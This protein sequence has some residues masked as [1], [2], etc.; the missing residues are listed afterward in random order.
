MDGI[1]VSDSY[2]TYGAAFAV[3]DIYYP[4]IEITVRNS[5]FEN[6]ATKSGYVFYSYRGRAASNSEYADN[7]AE[8][9]SKILL[10]MTDTIFR[11]NKNGAIAFSAGK[12]VADN[13]LFENNTGYLLYGRSTD[14]HGSTT[15]DI[16][17][18]NI[19]AI[20]NNNTAAQ[21]SLFYLT[22][23]NM[24]FAIRD[25]YALPEVSFIGLT[26]NNAFIY[27]NT[28]YSNVISMDFG[29]LNILNTTIV[30]NTSAN[31]LFLGGN[32]V[33]YYHYSHRPEVQILNSIILGNGV[34][35]KIEK[36]HSFD[37]EYTLY[38]TAE[39]A[40]K[41]Y[42]AETATTIDPDTYFS[43]TNTQLEDLDGKT[44]V[45]QVFLTDL[46][47]RT[48]NGIQ[49]A[50]LRTVDNS[51]A[52]NTLLTA[53]ETVRE[54]VSVTGL[55]TTDATSTKD[56]T[57]VYNIRTA[58]YYQLN[59]V[60]YG[61][62]GTEVSA[63]PTK[64]VTIT[65]DLLGNDRGATAQDNA[66]GAA[67][68]LQET[69]SLVVTTAEDMINYYDGKI[70]LRE[71][72]L[73]AA[74]NTAL[75]GVITF[76]AS[77]FSADAN[78]I[79]LNSTLD[80]NSS[81]QIRNNTG[82][83]I[84]ITVATPGMS[85]NKTLNSAASTYRLFT[86]EGDGIAVTIDGFTLTGGYLAA[87]NGGA[88]SVTGDGAELH[89][90]NSIVQKG[91]A[92]NGGGVYT[93]ADTILDVQK[94]Q[95][96]LNGGSDTTDSH[97]AGLYTGAKQVSIDGALFL[98]NGTAKTQNILYMESLS[99]GTTTEATVKNTMFFDN[100]QSSWSYGL[101]HAKG[102]NTQ[103]SAD[104]NLL[105]ESVSI[106]NTSASPW[107]IYHALTANCKNVTVINS[108]FTNA[109]GNYG[110]TLSLSAL[111]R[112]VVLNSTVAGGSHGNVAYGEI[113]KT[114]GSAILANNIFIGNDF[115]GG[116]SGM[117]L[118]HTR[119]GS[120]GSEKF[121]FCNNVFTR[122][123]MAQQTMENNIHVSEAR[124]VFNSTE[125][126]THF[127]LPADIPLLN[128]YTISTY[129]DTDLRTF[130]AA[131]AA[132]A[133]VA[134]DPATR[135]VF[136]RQSDNT[137]KHVNGTKDVVFDATANADWIISKDFYGNNRGTGIQTA[138]A[139]TLNATELLSLTGKIADTKTVSDVTLVTTGEDVINYFDGKISLR[140]A[141]GY[142]GDT[143]ATDRTVNFSADVNTVVTD[144]QFFI[145]SGLTIDGSREGLENVVIKVT[146][147]YG[148]ALAEAEAAGKTGTEAHEQAKDDAT[149]S[150]VFMV[151]NCWDVNQVVTLTNLTIQG[152]NP[153][154]ATKAASSSDSDANLGGA[155]Y[156][157]NCGEHTKIVPLILDHVT[158]SDTYAMEG[159]AIGFRPS[160]YPKSSLTIRDSIFEN[161]VSENYVAQQS[162]GVISTGTYYLNHTPN[163]DS[164]T[165]MSNSRCYITIE[166]TTFRNNINGGLL[167]Y[168]GHHVLD[169]LLF[170]NNTGIL[171]VTSAGKF[172]E[173]E[174]LILRNSSFVN[175]TASTD[176][177]PLLWFYTGDFYGKRYS[178][179][180]SVTGD[181][182]Y[183]NIMLYNVSILSNTG[184]KAMLQQEKGSI[185]IINTTVADN[186]DSIGLYLPDNTETTFL[187]PSHRVRAN[188]LNSVFLG[189]KTDLQIESVYRL[190][191]EYTVFGTREGTLKLYP[192]D[193]TPT[194]I[195]TFSATNKQLADA[196]GKTPFEQVYLATMPVGRFEVNGVN[197][198]FLFTADGE[199][200]IASAVTSTAFETFIE[201]VEYLNIKEGTYGNTALNIYSNIYYQVKG[202]WYL[203]GGDGTALTDL[204]DS[205]TVISTDQ[206]GNDR[207]T[208]AN[209]AA[210]A[211]LLTDIPGTVVQTA[212]D[213]SN[214]FDGK[215]SLRDAIAYSI[216]FGSGTAVTFDTTVFSA[217]TNTITLKSDIKLTDSVHIQNNTGK[218]IDIT[219]E[220]NGIASFKAETNTSGSTYRVMTIDGENITVTLEGLT[221]S[222]GYLVNGKGAVIYVAGSGSE[223][224][225][226]GT[227][228][229]KGA[230][231]HGGG[232][233]AET[234]TVLTVRN[235]SRFMLNASIN[236][237]SG[238]A[239]YMNIGSELDFTDSLIYQNGNKYTYSA[240][241]VNEA[242]ASI[243]NSV[244]G[245]NY[246][247]AP[248]DNYGVLQFAKSD[249]VLDNLTFVGHQ[250]QRGAFIYHDNS[251]LLMNRVSALNN[252]ASVYSARF[253]FTGG[254][255]TILN[256]DFSF[257][258]GYDGLHNHIAFQRRGRK[259][260]P[261]GTC[262]NA[263]SGCC[264]NK[265]R[266]DSQAVQFSVSEHFGFCSDHNGKLHDAAGSVLDLRNGNA[267]RRHPLHAGCQ[268]LYAVPPC[269]T[270]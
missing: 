83:V 28:G 180:E 245:D 74:A 135:N 178:T 161:N 268:Y 217:D 127:I 209:N 38:S 240:V 41:L 103:L 82:K 212:D 88:I 162:G 107:Q 261:D 40:M 168:G 264:R 186:A 11:G 22:A 77:V 37:M 143:S 232:V 192:A 4:A 5:V 152:G 27:G 84:E 24:T 44:P 254:D 122:M 184:Y 131:G 52:L 92:V 242:T 75:G 100:F 181:Q 226:D 89:L 225:L 241:L 246:I 146:K 43:T 129:A 210:G 59:D 10:T 263:R 61:M 3:T 25:K 185:Y 130:G 174:D 67:N 65:K 151:V 35:I 17:L 58:L 15:I 132:G 128:D 213:V 158:I 1:T 60:W 95:F 53:Y 259:L 223:L 208:A 262:R 260:G 6:N 153:E 140:E 196:D 42:A 258:K 183:S 16:T 79:T 191:M 21:G 31:G 64:A 198:A 266:C 34:D 175:N 167:L 18:S 159:S 207:T 219:V 250:I 55:L 227:T 189:N 148:E 78:V 144:R 96:Y 56:F 141:I 68:V 57:N 154:T 81:L 179:N 257:T 66:A 90:L 243:R 121:V 9:S 138:G 47:Y 248:Q 160:N 46:H 176:T 204:A 32:N 19:T 142:A 23:N 120:A 62:D 188:I 29:K 99:S 105:V 117:N 156:L 106:S 163:Y 49:H 113:F 235:N 182:S 216:L 197:Q 116:V 166:N 195:S 33:T 123:N 200:P 54:G 133:L 224:I 73:Y 76:D 170:E 177:D 114:E 48:V 155:I 256:S 108:S 252:S 36:V 145:N 249:V 134:Y 91:A 51:P 229:Q 39:G 109:S 69:K 104:M 7:F 236:A 85:G 14:V 215:V 231:M 201:G 80:I 255:V 230:A 171:L 269:K 63:L 72:I 115:Y 202:S 206:V 126:N 239:I 218:V 244:I 45:E 98:N 101:F 50:A 194:E 137:W 221:L 187:K 136:V 157:M 102:V 13:L 233:Y 20:N 87:A 112:L 193:G 150:R 205:A 237:G 26:I 124:M 149:D 270:Q 265:R 93:G 234:D 111:E 139:V 12:M 214:M 251:T 118:S 228:V 211:T 172:G 169:N 2:A 238:A 119:S 199:N 97:G 247:Q 222:G 70:S 220:S 267:D 30:N 71:A 165:G 203:M 86:I 253:V 125:A 147:T 8:S 164:A 94:V 190:N 173:A 110:A